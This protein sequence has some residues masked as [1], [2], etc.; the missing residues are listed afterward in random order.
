MICTYISP[1]FYG[2]L[3]V[4]VFEREKEEVCVCGI[5]RSPAHDLLLSPTVH[6]LVR[7]LCSVC[8]P[9]NV[10]LQSPRPHG[11]NT[12][13]VSLDIEKTFSK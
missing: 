7:L 11:D 3:C 13:L 4:F 9:M 1:S 8:V 12:R 5:F 10:S 2:V 6:A